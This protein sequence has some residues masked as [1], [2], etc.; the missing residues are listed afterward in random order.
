M[1][2][3]TKDKR[4]LKFTPTK[5]IDPKKEF[6]AFWVLYLE[7]LS[8]FAIKS[9]K[10]R[11]KMRLIH[12]GDQGPYFPKFK[13]ENIVFFYFLGKAG[14]LCTLLGWI[15]T[16]IESRIGRITTFFEKLKQW[17]TVGLFWVSA[18]DLNKNCRFFFY[19]FHLLREKGQGHEIRMAWKW[20]GKIGLN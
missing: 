9:A 20:Y 10:L 2:W 6:L 13:A 18:K 12:D 1:Y 17:I 4:L 11:P 7:N 14:T 19:I 15:Q 5:A 8:K 3:Y 16:K